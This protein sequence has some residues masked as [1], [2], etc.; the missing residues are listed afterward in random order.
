MA[1]QIPLGKRMYLF[2]DDDSQ[3]DELIITSHGGYYEA[4]KFGAGT[5]KIPVPDWTSLAF[6]GPH[7]YV[8]ADPSLSNVLNGGI[9]IYKTAGPGKNVI[10][11]SLSKYQ[12]KHGNK[13]E[14]YATIM[15]SIGSN[16]NLEIMRQE[17]LGSGDNDK[18]AMVNKIAPNAF[19][20]FDVLTVRNRYF[21]G[22]DPNLLDVLDELDRTDHKYSKIHCVFCRSPMNFGSKDQVYT[23]P[24]R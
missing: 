9:K 7:T 10:N 15:T 6:Y 17:A 20:K 11:Y 21:K 5:K 3:A 13:N 19:P 22:G 18:I 4:G 8:L 14:T 12:G 16:R 2:M 23:A 1:R 24:K